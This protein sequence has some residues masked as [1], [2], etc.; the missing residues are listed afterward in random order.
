MAKPADR[1][2]SRY[3]LDALALLGRL[4]R[5][6]RIDHRMT[7]EDLAQRAGI[8]RGLLHR[9]ERGDPGAAIGAVLETAAIVGV[10]LFEAD[11][12]ALAERV[13]GAGERL[14]LLPKA[15]RPAKTAVR[16]DF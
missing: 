1:A 6:G 16:D 9:I 5:M 8:S 10:P 7:A 2:Y 13:R 14:S 15:V 12:G 3:A 11:R 4:I